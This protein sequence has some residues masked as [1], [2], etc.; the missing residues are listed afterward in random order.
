MSPTSSIFKHNIYTGVPLH[1]IDKVAL[2]Y[3]D[4]PYGTGKRFKDYDD[5]EAGAL[6]VAQAVITAAAML[7]QPGGM[8]V[9]QCDHRINFRVRILLE[10]SSYLSFL[11]EIVWTYASGGAGKKKLPQKHD[12]LF[13]YYKNDGEYTFNVLREPYPRDYGNRP[14]FHPDGRMI[15]SVWNIPILS[16]TS[17]ERT[18]YA[19]EKP[20]KLLERVIEVFSAPGSL[21]Y[22]PCCGSGTTGLAAKSLGRKFALSD[23][24]PD[25]IRVSRERMS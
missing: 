11:N 22:D 9:L 23:L 1:L 6:G 15:T 18:G 19:T 21:V 24:N 25:A 7:L 2:L 3:A 20:P 8:L 17:K 14:G 4:L 12:T 16:T 5:P 10:R 13:A